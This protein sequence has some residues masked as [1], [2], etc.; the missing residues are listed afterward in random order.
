[1]TAPQA[2]DLAA[3]RY[4]LHVHSTV[5]D[6]SSTPAELAVI[7]AEAG[8]AGFALTDHDTLGGLDEAA[9]ACACA[10][11]ELIPGVELT[12]YARRDGRM[13]EVHMLGLYVEPESPVLQES[14]VEFREM[15]VRRV[16]R[17]SQRLR[18]MG[19]DLGTSGV[20]RH[21]P[22]GSVGR[23]HVAQELVRLGVCR[24]QQ[25]AFDRFIGYGRPAYVPKKQIR[26]AE[27]VEIIRAAGGCAV[28]AHPGVTDDS[29]S[30]IEELSGRGLAGVEVHYPMHSAEQERH[31][32]DLTR[33]LTLV[34]TG[35]S[36]FHGSPKPG[37]RIGME[38]VSGVEVKALA[39]RRPPKE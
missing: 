15:R 27:G 31:Y 23:V 18:E 22:T 4:D 21:S 3:R 33:R 17:I 16:E 34:V 12:T 10:G 32:M 36:D 30:L 20:M 19:V 39:E 13:V 7:A 29:D 11:V 5:S 9:E 1:M 8:L 25:D 24:D 28:F 37:I 2:E 6:G 14:L 35:G 26:P 38:A